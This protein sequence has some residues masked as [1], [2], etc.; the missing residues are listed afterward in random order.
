M[1][2]MLAGW[3]Y[4]WTGLERLCNAEAGNVL[5]PI[6]QNDNI[7]NNIQH[8]LETTKKIYIW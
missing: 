8:F 7:N 4:H 5:S 3:H 6:R 1:N 2:G